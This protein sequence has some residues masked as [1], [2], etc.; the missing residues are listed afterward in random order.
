MD[1]FIDFINQLYQANKPTAETLCEIIKYYQTNHF[2]IEW[3]DDPRIQFN[4][5]NRSPIIEAIKLS[6]NILDNINT[7]YYCNAIKY[8]IE[9]LVMPCNLEE[10][11]IDEKVIEYLKKSFAYD[12]SNGIPI[13]DDCYNINS[14]D[15]TF[16]CFNDDRKEL[17]IKTKR[18]IDY[19]MFNDPYRN[20]YYLSYFKCAVNFIVNHPLFKKYDN[21]EYEELINNKEY[22][23]S[24][25]YYNASIKLWKLLSDNKF[26][27]IVNFYNNITDNQNCI[28]NP[29]IHH[30]PYK[31]LQELLYYLGNEFSNM[32]YRLNH[33]IFF[34]GYNKGYME[35]YLSKCDI[36]F[37]LSRCNQKSI[38]ICLPNPFGHFEIQ[39]LWN[40]WD[41]YNEI[42]GYDYDEWTIPKA[43]KY[44]LDMLTRKK[45][46]NYDY[47]VGDYYLTSFCFTECIIDSNIYYRHVFVKINY[48]ENF[49]V[50]SKVRYDDKEMEY[51]QNKYQFMDNE[52]K[53]FNQTG[54]NEYYDKNNKYHINMLCY[55]KK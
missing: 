49:N 31:I 44:D 53:I 18:Y 19:D 54:I 46:I 9:F 27:N 32:F 50:I 3:L 20:F 45:S 37:H 2:N 23:T 4:T 12:R 21:K 28:A 34:G 8:G 42:Y 47:L 25:Y 11:R 30:N 13:Y 41:D 43:I 29:D 35:Y 15:Y 17:K 36:E 16:N 51:E 24:N 7:K 48:D 38:F 52:L 22:E 40:F 5:S 6:A 14:Y 10:K 1:K 55:V 33:F 39:D 26:T